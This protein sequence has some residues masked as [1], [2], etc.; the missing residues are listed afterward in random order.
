MPFNE[1]SIVSI[2]DGEII[3]VIG[4]DSDLEDNSAEIWGLF[5]AKSKWNIAI[6]LQSEMIKI[7]PEEIKTISLFINKKMKTV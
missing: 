7:L 2:E 5:I 1:S 4:F 3:G 6:D